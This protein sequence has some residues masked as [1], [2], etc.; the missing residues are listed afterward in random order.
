MANNAI[1]LLA[2]VPEFDTPAESEAKALQVEAL[3]DAAVQR[4]QA[5][6]DDTAV[7]DVYRNNTDA[8]SR[9]KALY[10]VSPKAAMAAQK[11]ELEFEQ[12]G[13]ET[14]KT[15]AA[16]RASDI[17]TARKKI[18]AIG[19][20]LGY[21]MKNPTADA[22][23]R[24][25]ASLEQYGMLTA[26][27]AADYRTQIAANPSPE[28]I[29][30]LATES[31]T[32]AL[33]AKEQLAKIETRDIGGSVQTTRT[34]PV[35]GL[36][37]VVSTT[38]KTQSPDS[39]ASIEQQERNSRRVDARARESNDRQRLE[40][41]GQVVQTDEGMMLVDPRGATARPIIGAD[42]VPVAP[43]MRPI[44]A[45]IQ[46]ALL[47]NDA[48]LRKVESALEAVAKY[49]EGLGVKNYLGDGIRQR[50][51]PDGVNVRALVADIGSLKIHDR[52]GAAVTASETPRLKP[53]IPA[54]TDDPVTVEKK[55]RL[56][57]KEYQEIQ[58]DINGTYTREQGYRPPAKL[59]KG[60]S[61]DRE[62]K[63]ARPV[64]PKPGTIKDGYR[65]KGG[66][67]SKEQNWERV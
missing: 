54:A 55:L 60:A 24:A 8:G 27:E 38:T 22:A 52:S 36:Q 19:Q 2:K 39:V 25:I 16:T 49:P 7:R 51:D 1:A 46:K 4:R 5:T 12:M 37:N 9:I 17:E 56:F 45:P 34:D 6:A 14:G 63:P 47:E 15:K 64:G 18:D 11:A 21:V 32:A 42:G 53:F 61:G 23:S 35:S 40:P 58:E 41:R 62:D 3:R 10:G 31:Y 29:K 44:P 66:D 26:E 30:E 48:A 65:F 28:K 43:K 59:N 67:P 57:Q 50:S 13:A 20:T 33:D